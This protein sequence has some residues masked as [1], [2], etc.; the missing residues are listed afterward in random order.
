MPGLA[1]NRL[2][3]I[4]RYNIAVN[5]HD[6]TNTPEKQLNRLNL[7]TSPYPYPSPSGP[8]PLTHPS[9]LMVKSASSDFMY[10]DAH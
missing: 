6:P 10:Y 7:T 3:P 5:S 1:A 2:N 9:F 4:S 8:R